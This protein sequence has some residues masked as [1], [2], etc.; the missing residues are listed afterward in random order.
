MVF[1]FLAMPSVLFLQIQTIEAESNQAPVLISDENVDSFVL[2]QKN[3]LRPVCSPPQKEVL[4]NT[5]ARKIQVMVT[6]YSSTPWQTDSTPFI[7]AAGTSVRDGIVATNILPF[8]TK[9]KIPRIYGDK[10]FV[11][12]DRM[13]PRKHYYI[14]I[15]F[16][17]Y[18]QAKNFGVKETYIEILN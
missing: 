18:W 7:T 9:I 8:G 17:S 2:V 10:I 11:V 1:S 6:A 5:K 13:H 12:E 3:T 14:D 15:W 4:N 16:P